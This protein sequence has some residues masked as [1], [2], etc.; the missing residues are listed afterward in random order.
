EGNP[1]AEMRALLVEHD[2]ARVERRVD[3]V[4]VVGLCGG[5]VTGGKAA[6]IRAC[7]RNVER[8]VLRVDC[9]EEVVEGAGVDLVAERRLVREGA[10]RREAGNLLVRCASGDHE[11][12]R[13]AGRGLQ[14]PAPR[15]F[16]AH[17]SGAYACY[18]FW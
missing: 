9:I 18:A 5:D 6:D 2:D 14:E 11:G 8:G 7:R 16:T 1:A 15:L 10:G 13:R 4:G 12:R 3:G 17:D